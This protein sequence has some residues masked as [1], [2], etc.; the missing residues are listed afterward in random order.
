MSKLKR[1]RPSLRPLLSVMLGAVVL[2][3][4]LMLTGPASAQAVSSTFGG[5]SK[6]SGAPIDIESD[7]LVVHDAQKYATFK[8]KVKAVQG[9]T[10]IRCTELDVHYVGSGADSLT[11][12]PA[13]GGAAA[14]AATPA[15]ADTSAKTEVKAGEEA[16]PAAG[17]GLGNNGTQISKIEAKGDVIITSEQDQTTTSD[18]ALYDVPAQ[19]VTVGGNVVLMQGKNVLKG[20]RL[21]ID[22]KTGESRFE[23]PGNAAA[24]GRIRA[25]FMPKQDAKS[26]TEKTANEKSDQSGKEG[27]DNDKAAAKPASGAELPVEKAPAQPA[28]G[29][30]P[31]EKAPATPTSGEPPSD[32]EAWQLLPGQ[33]R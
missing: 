30:A 23:N 25:L 20:D 15:A 12:E 32:S 6:N 31:I 27:T 5:L 13:A 26:G 28:S 8:G 29:E 24:P 11:G 17:A 21:V 18:W 22:L 1:R 14:T 33:Q 10:T 3:L 7:V 9:T 2:A 16:K 4:G 19:L